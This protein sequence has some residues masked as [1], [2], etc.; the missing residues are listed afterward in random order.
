M[1]VKLES[2][3]TFILIVPISFL[4]LLSLPACSSGKASKT[5]VDGTSDPER[6]VPVKVVAAESRQVRR[7]VE[8]VGSLFPYD[9]T[10]VS[11]EVDG[12]A[13]NVLVDVGDQVTKGQTLVEILSTEFKLTSEQ[14]EALLE[15]AKAK[16]GLTASD[17]EVKDPAQAPSV[18]K[19]AADLANAEQKFKRS[20]ALFEQGILARQTYEEDESTYKAAQATYDLAVQD[21]KNLQAILRQQSAMSD[22]AKKKLRDTKILAPF[23]G[24]VKERDVTIGQYVKVQTPVMIVVNVDPLRARLKI[25]EKVAAW[26]P[27]G[28]PVTVSVEAYPDRT[29]SGKIWRINPSVDPQTRTFDAEAL[30][31]NHGRALKPGFFAKASIQSTKVE[32]VLFVPQRALSYAYGIY[33]VYKVKENKLKAIE[34]KLGDR[35]GQDV[36]VI[37]G[38]SQGDRLALPPDGQELKDGASIEPI[39]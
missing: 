35:A 22:L 4:M 17:G 38:I 6:I 39:P 2:R 18:K 10:V 8:A 3:Q 34:V 11:S 26:V 28:Q 37:E 5:K 24:Y 20:K 31:E 14:Q 21:V 32:R 33:K 25:P 36:E 15:G 12:R 16:L 13:E 29:F 27:V 1:E 19:A 9:E 30:V 23:D 7:T